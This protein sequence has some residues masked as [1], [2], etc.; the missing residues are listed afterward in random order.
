MKFKNYL[1][2][3]E[4]FDN[5]YKVVHH[6]K[7]DAYVFKTED[8]ELYTITIFKTSSGDQP[9]YMLYFENENGDTHITNQGNAFRILATVIDV[10]LIEKSNIEKTKGLVFSAEEKSRKSLYLALVKKL[11]NKLKFKKFSTF[12]DGK[13]YFALYDDVE[14]LN[15]L[16]G[17]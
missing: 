16:T 6:P 17:K 12:T 1:D 3:N 14:L 10:V 7:D 8:G 11:K 5:P 13:E 2:I 9:Y 4:A 15:K